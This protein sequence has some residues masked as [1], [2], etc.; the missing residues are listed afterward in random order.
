MPGCG[1][2][3]IGFNDLRTFVTGLCI[4]NAEDRKGYLRA[5]K[6]KVRFS[7]QK[8]TGLPTGSFYWGTII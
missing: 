4:T 6:R 1:I 7:K 8:R 3:N 5:G 2:G